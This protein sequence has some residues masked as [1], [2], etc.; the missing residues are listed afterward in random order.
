MAIPPERAKHMIRKVRSL[1]LRLLGS[2]LPLSELG[3]QET[4][5]K[6]TLHR[7][8]EVTVERET[9]STFVRGQLVEGPMEAVSRKKG[10]GAACKELPPQKSPMPAED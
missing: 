10:P 7:R 2:I 9:V 3:E 4:R 6:T 5:V 8:F 1:C